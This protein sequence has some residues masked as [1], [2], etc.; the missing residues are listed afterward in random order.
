MQYKLEV[1][2]NLDSLK[3]VSI[4]EFQKENYAMNQKV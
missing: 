3:R 1:S 2:K 4:S